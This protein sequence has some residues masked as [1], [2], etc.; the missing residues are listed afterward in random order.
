ME[1][2]FR[3]LL[4]SEDG[5]LLLEVGEVVDE[6]EAPLLTLRHVHVWNNKLLVIKLSLK[7]PVHTIIC[8][9]TNKG[10]IPLY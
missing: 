8:N 7:G 2:F 6:L 3:N 5:E 9:F 1:V 10:A 4:F